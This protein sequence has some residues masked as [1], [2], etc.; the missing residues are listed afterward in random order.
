MTAYHQSR[1]RDRLRT[2]AWTLRRLLARLAPPDTS[3]TP[4]YRLATNALSARHRTRALQNITDSGD[5]VL[6]L[7]PGYVN[8]A[9]SRG[10]RNFDIGDEWGRLVD[11]AIDPWISTLSS[12][13]RSPLEATGSCSRSRGRHPSNWA[14]NALID[15]R[16][17]D[18]IW[19]VVR[20]RT[21]ITLELRLAEDADWKA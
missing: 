15:M 7:Y 18:L 8:K 11:Q 14:G 13:R 20:D 12:W 17:G 16:R 21:Q 6:G 9:R 1:R 19:C 2:L 4:H 3:T 5:T 10:A